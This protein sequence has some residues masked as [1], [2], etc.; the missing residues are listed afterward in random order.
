MM[1]LFSSIQGT[2]KSVSCADVGTS[3]IA[4]STSQPLLT[5]TPIKRPHK[6][7]RLELEEEE[8]NPLEG[9]SSMDIRDPKDSTFDP[10]DTVTVLSEST[11]V[12]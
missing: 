12:T 3:T 2:Q 5:S 6:R 11:D 7:A 10:E 4:F 9:S 1:I 8:E